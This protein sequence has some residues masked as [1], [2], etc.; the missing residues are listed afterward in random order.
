MEK[1]SKLIEHVEA[2]GVNKRITIFM[3]EEADKSKCFRVITKTLID[4]KSRHIVGTDNLYSVETFA[5]LK[6]LFS[7]VLDNSKVRNKLCLKQLAD[8]QLFNV[9]TSLP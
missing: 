5:V 8:R 4:F 6:D 9:K 1:K 2:K 7:F 3:Y